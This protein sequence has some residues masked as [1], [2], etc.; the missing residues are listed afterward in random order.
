MD[1]PLP[2]PL[3]DVKAASLA[4]NQSLKSTKMADSPAEI[5]KAVKLYTFIGL[6]LFIGTIITVAVAT[7]EPLDIHHRGLDWA[8][9]TLGLIIASVKA[10][11]VM[12][13]FM[14]LN[15]EKPLVYLFYGMA[16]VMAFFC[17][18]LTGWSK[19][20]PIEYG[21]PTKGDGFYNA[22]ETLPPRR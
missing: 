10:G 5:K 19:A 12:Y 1:L 18:F 3:L 11:L 2:D 9:V 4:F 17:M 8:D 20:D 16:I 15:H 6:T 22:G 13:F 7:V 14:H 21:D